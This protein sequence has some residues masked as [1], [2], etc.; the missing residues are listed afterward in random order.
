MPERRNSVEQAC[1]EF[2]ESGG[3]SIGKEE[4]DKI[5]VWIDGAYQEYKDTHPDFND[6]GHDFPMEVWKASLRKVMEYGKVSTGRKKHVPIYIDTYI[7]QEANGHFSTL[8]EVGG[9]AFV[10]EAERSEIIVYLA[11]MVYQNKISFE[12]ACRKL[13]YSAF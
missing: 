5:L 4:W 6:Y 8:V 11:M 13:R 3:V 12:E 9:K 7:R 10:I 2:L 1:Q